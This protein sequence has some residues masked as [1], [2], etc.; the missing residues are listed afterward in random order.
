LL[1]DGRDLPFRERFRPSLEAPDRSADTPVDSLASA[2][3]SGGPAASSGAVVRSGRRLC[4]ASDRRSFGVQVSILGD[5]RSRRQ[6]DPGL[7]MITL[8]STGPR[9]GKA[10]ACR[11][12]A[13]RGQRVTVAPRRGA[14]Q[15]RVS[16]AFPHRP[17]GPSAPFRSAGGRPG[18]LQ[19]IGRST[20]AR[21]RALPP[22]HGAI[23]AAQ[24]DAGR[25][26]ESGPG[27]AVCGPGRSLCAFRSRVRVH[28]LDRAAGWS[29][30]RRGPSDGRDGRQT[31]P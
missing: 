19:R 24:T 14:D 23:S 20:G 22:P 3:A 15:P 10:P 17:A 4:P 18:C 6:P 12:S 25:G 13:R 28:R 27:A 11:R 7:E 8:R 29:D 9:R 5:T 2:R 16:R 21:P 26:G 30:D 1:V 31:G